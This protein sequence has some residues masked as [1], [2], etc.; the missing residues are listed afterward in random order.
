MAA[1]IN[2]HINLTKYAMNEKIFISG[3]ITGNPTYLRDF[4][5]A[6]RKVQ[7]VNFG[8]D[9]TPLSYVMRHNKIIRFRPIVPTWF[10]VFGYPLDDFPWLTC[11]IVCLWR[12]VWCSHV[13]M[14]IG[15][16]KSRGACIEHKWARRLHKHIIYER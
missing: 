16:N 15:W 8:Y 12:L 7:D 5:E 9:N 1:V 3:P 13:Y 2:L 6:A 14:L 10:K 4:D 11:M